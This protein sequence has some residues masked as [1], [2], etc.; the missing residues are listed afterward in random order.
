MKY[1]Q[2]RVLEAL[3]AVQAFLDKHADVLGAINT[4]GARK[5]VDDIAAELQAH[6]VQQD[7]GLRKSVGE[8]SK[9]RELRLALRFAMRPIAE[10]AAAK[11]R[12]APQFAALRLPS[13]KRRGMAMVAAAHAMADAAVGHGE[14]FTA[15]GLPAGFIDQLRNAAEAL[16]ASF[17]V[18]RDGQTARMGATRG[19]R[20]T[21]RRGRL[22]LRVVDSLVVPALGHDEALLAAWRGARRIQRK[23]GPPQEMGQGPGE[24]A[25]APATGNGVLLLPGSPAA[26]PP[27]PERDDDDGEKQAA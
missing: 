15:A 25:P 13:W 27:A 3:H 12:E 18:R 5:N 22:A 20:E 19:L 10:V 16:S 14:I 6:A 11:L 24:P 17:G 21:E 8:T 1:E 23:P 2:G 9:Q 26:A 7:G 4:S